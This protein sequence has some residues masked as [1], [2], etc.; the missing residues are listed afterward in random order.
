ML[1]WVNTSANAS[2]DDRNR[3]MQIAYQQIQSL[4]QEPNSPLQGSA[5]WQWYAPGQEA[6]PTEGGGSGLFGIRETD[7]A[8][9]LITDNIK[10]IQGLNGPVPGCSLAAHKAAPV[11]PVNDCR[12]TWVNNRP[13][14]G[15]DGPDCKTPINE[16]VRG[17]ADCDKN[18]ACIDTDSGYDCRCFFAYDG[19]GKKC[20]PNNQA[21]LTLQHVYWSEPNG[22]SCKPG[23]PVDYPDYSPGFKY[24][25]M[26]SFA[27]FVTSGGGK[28]G[29]KSNVTLTQCM[30]ACQ[31][32]P[33][34]ESFVYNDVLQQCFLS[35]G[36]CPE[37]NYCQGEQ[38]KCVSTNDRGGQFSFD[39][40]YWVSF[41]RLDADVQS[42]CQGFTPNPL[43]VGTP[44]PAALAPFAAY[45]QANPGVPVRSTP[46]MPTPGVEPGQVAAA[47]VPLVDTSAPNVQAAG[48]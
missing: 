7:A 47:S 1:Q 9:S 14:T 45:K 20:T 35:R 2:V 8:F 40:G 43:S 34:C 21:L 6:A 3:F 39:C 17:T 12:S 41:Y 33:T 32:A 24:D 5:F 30:I 11:A 36:Q 19:D 37:Y 18:A 29:S 28:L 22:L 48:K 13:G 46:P 44:N 25:P 16:C 4:M 23:L 27:F 15:Y 42:A 10:F 31:M 26:N 38:A